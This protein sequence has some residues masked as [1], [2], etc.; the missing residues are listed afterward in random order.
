MSDSVKFVNYQ[1]HLLCVLSYNTVNRAYK[2]LP[3]HCCLL[4]RY[5][6]NCLLLTQGSK[7]SRTRR[8]L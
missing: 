5:I 6:T 7:C 2:Q 3:G 8:T 1:Q 4:A